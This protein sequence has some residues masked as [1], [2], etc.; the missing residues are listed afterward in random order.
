VAAE[1]GGAG[2][3]L[4]TAQRPDAVHEVDA[5]DLPVPAG[6]TPDYVTYDDG[7]GSAAAIRVD[8]WAH[9]ALGN[10]VV[11]I[12]DPCLPPKTGWGLHHEEHADVAW[13]QNGPAAGAVLVTGLEV[14]LH[15]STERFPAECP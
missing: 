12:Y 5:A 4:V 11:F 9:D 8:V 2:L 13:V 3:A 1:T 10:V 15:P 6:F 7:G 14:R